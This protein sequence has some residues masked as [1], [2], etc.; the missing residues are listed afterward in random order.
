MLFYSSTAIKYI[1]FVF[2]LI[3][4]VTG[5]ALLGVGIVIKGVYSEYEAFLDDRF[6]SAPSLLVF[7]GTIIF[8]IAFF[9]CCGAIRENHCMVMTFSILMGGIFVLELVAGI[10][11][12]ILSDDT[13]EVLTAK[14]N[15]SMLQ[16]NHS[17]ELTEVWDQLQERLHCCGTKNFSDWYPVL[18]NS[19]PMSCCG[20]TTGAIDHLTCNAQ[21]VT[22]YHTPCLKSL[23]V[24][25]RDNAVTIGGAGIS[26]AFIQLLGVVFA[27]NLARSIRSHYESV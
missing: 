10:T 27:C 25:I 6:F 17:L 7:V 14:L 22:L 1:L 16:Y 3:F 4:V 11:G 8:F 15:S 13:T 2:N 24:L 12:Y 23:S 18:N 19:L 9:G 26:I 21:S 5:I 20:P